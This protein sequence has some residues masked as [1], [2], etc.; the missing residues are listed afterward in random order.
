MKRKLQFDATKEQQFYVAK[1]KTSDY[2]CCYLVQ[3][4]VWTFTNQKTPKI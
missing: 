1:K 3:T 4:Y 2:C